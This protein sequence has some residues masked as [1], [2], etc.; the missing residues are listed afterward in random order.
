[1]RYSEVLPTV[2]WAAVVV[3]ATVGAWV[4]VRET[5]LVVTDA[6]VLVVS[7]LAILGT[8]VALRRLARE[9]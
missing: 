5:K 9:E 4:A 3:L 1:M 7:T 2:L 8:A 6:S